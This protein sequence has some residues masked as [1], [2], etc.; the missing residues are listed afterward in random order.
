MVEKPPA[1]AGGAGSIPGLEDST[2]WEG[3]KP[4]KPQLLSPCSTREA[5]AVRSPHTETRENPHIATKTQHSQP[6]INTVIPKKKNL[7]FL[8]GSV[9]K[10]SS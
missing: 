8:C 10:E 3:T 9:G 2:R 6:K 5:P 1:N 4:M 7:G